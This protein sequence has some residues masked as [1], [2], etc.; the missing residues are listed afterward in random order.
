MRMR[1]KRISSKTKWIALDPKTLHLISQA[2]RTSKN[3]DDD[4]IHRLES[5]TDQFKP[6]CSSVMHLSLSPAI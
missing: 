5:T 3:P 6:H 1:G 4:D 2:E